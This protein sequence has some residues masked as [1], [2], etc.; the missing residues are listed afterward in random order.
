MNHLVEEA[1]ILLQ[2]QDFS[3]AICGDKFLIAKFI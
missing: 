3:Y 1:K 2:G